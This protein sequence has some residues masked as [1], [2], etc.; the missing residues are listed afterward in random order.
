MKGY[1]WLAVA[2][3]LGL[4]VLIHFGGGGAAPS[5]PAVA[6]GPP[7]RVDLRM[8]PPAGTVYVAAAKDQ[9]TGRCYVQIDAR[10]LEVPCSEIDDLPSVPFRVKE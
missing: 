1:H 7:V 6:P 5:A 10:W 8:T 9:R 4:A 3:G 2:V